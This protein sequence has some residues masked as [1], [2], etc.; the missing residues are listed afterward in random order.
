ML[1]NLE[2]PSV[3]RLDV[4]NEFLT[5]LDESE[6]LNCKEQYDAREE[7]TSTHS[8]EESSHKVQKSVENHFSVELVEDQWSWSHK[9]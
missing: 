6:A 4:A 1:L 9:S 5:Y 7:S 3:K 2:V 8:N